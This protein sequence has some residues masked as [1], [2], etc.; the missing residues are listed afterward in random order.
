[1][2]YNEIIKKYTELIRLAFTNE[3]K[4]KNGTKIYVEENQTGTR[5]RTATKFTEL[6][7]SLTA[8]K[9]FRRDK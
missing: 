9:I 7:V 1:M 3:G 4:N 5:R 6:A 2:L 8:S